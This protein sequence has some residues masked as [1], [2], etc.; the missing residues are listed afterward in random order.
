MASPGSSVPTEGAAGTP[1]KGLK[2]ANAIEATGEDV[3]E[4]IQKLTN[5]DFF[6]ARENV[7]VRFGPQITGAIRWHWSLAWLFWL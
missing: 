1:S 3:Q 2:M 7:E 5:D 4:A 6:G